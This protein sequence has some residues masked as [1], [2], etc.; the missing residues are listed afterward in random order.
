MFVSPDER[1][2]L[3]KNVFSSLK[4]TQKQLKTP[5]FVEFDPLLSRGDSCC[6]CPEQLKPITSV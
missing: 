5:P 4:E 3:Q 1:K 6:R 2:S